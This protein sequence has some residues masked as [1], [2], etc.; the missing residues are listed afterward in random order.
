[1]V[2]TAQRT[3]QVVATPAAA[4]VPVAEDA[5]VPGQGWK[6]L[7]WFG[8]DVKSRRPH[9]IP[10]P[11]SVPALLERILRDERDGR[12][13]PSPWL[14]PS[15]RG[16][17]HVTQ[18]S[19]NQLLYRLGGRGG[20]ADLLAL[21]EIRPWTLHDVRRSLTTF[22]RDRRLGAAASAILDHAD[23]RHDERDAVS[24]VTRLH[25]DRSQRIALKAE[26]LAAW[27]DAVL[28]AFETERA[29]VSSVRAPSP[30]PRTRRK[31]ERKLAA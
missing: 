10:L 21:Y 13:V 20:R 23:G 8:A 16:D 30:P 7:A 17:G 12:E 29:Y 18:T 19:L 14:F 31:A 3:G 4:L 11:P 26:G 25:Y 9:V 27:V 22:L 6:S 15:V 28:D 2:L 24:A 5:G 1:V